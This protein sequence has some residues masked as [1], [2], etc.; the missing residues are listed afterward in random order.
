MLDKKVLSHIVDR[1][2]GII[3]FADVDQ[4]DVFEAKV[5][6]FFGKE[7]VAIDHVRPQLGVPVED[8]VRYIDHSKDLIRTILL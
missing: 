1:D 5:G 2:I 7:A 4:G 6:Q 8:C 3:Y